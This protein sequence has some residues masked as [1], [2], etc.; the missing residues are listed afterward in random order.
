[1]LLHFVIL[2]SKS[3]KNKK[4]SRA[5]ERHDQ[6]GRFCNICV[7]NFRTIFVAV[8][9]K[10]SLFS[11]MMCGPTADSRFSMIRRTV[12]SADNVSA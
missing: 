8:D 4:R 5:Q 7:A 3:L 9:V 1:L 6:A 10:E 2:G 12:C 11:S